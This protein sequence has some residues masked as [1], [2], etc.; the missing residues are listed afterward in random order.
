MG[1]IKLKEVKKMTAVRRSVAIALVA[2]L[3]A[4]AFALAKPAK[5]QTTPVATGNLGDLIVLNG[6]FSNPYGY[7][8][9]YGGYYGNNLM[10]LAGLIAVNNATMT[11]ATAGAPTN[12]GDLIVL[13][14]LFNNPYGYY[15]GYYGNN[16]M[17][18]AGL[19]AVNNVTATP[20]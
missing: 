3:F 15:G 6:L 12:L 9:G 10:G 7:G 5:A 14:G 2:A 4:G 17:G 8:Y 11:G 20:F 16:L 1:E 13:N 19:I 18:L